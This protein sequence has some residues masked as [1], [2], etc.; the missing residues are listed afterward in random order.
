[1]SKQFKFEISGREISI[2]TGRLARLA[3][4]AVLIRMADT[5]VLATA[6]AG[7]KPREGV[8]FLPLV[9][10]Y[11]EKA[12]AAGKIPGGFFKREGRP[13]ER[14]I[15]SSRLIDRPLR[16]LFPDG[17]RHETQI[18][19]NVLSA[20]QENDPDILGIIGASCALHISQI[21]FNGPIGAVRVGRVDGRLIINPT[22]TQ[23]TEGDLNIVVVGTKDS[24][25]M[26]EAGAGIVG[27]EVI[28]SALKAAQEEIRKIVIIQEEM[29]E[30]IG[31]PKMDFIPDI[32]GEDLIDR[33]KSDFGPAIK[34]AIVVQG[35]EER[36]NALSKIEDKAVEK[37]AEDEELTA[38][39][40][41]IFS[42]LE[43]KYARK[44]ILEEN[45]RVDGRELKEI[46]P[47]TCE[48][49]SL[50]RTHGSAIFTRGETQALAITTLGT[51]DDE[52]MLDDLGT[53][54]SKSFMLH[55]NFPPFSVGEAGFLRGPGRR[56]IGHGALAER[57][58]RIS[59]PDKEQF[60]YT[61]R[62]VSEILESNGSSSMATICASSLSLMDAGVPIHNPIAGI[63]MGL[64]KEGDKVVILSD[65][66]GL[67]DHYGDMDFKVAGCRDGITALQMDIK[68]G[69]ITPVVMEE[70]L[71]QAREGRLFILDKML[72]T[73][74]APR[75]SISVYAPR[76]LTMKIK[77][78]KIREVIG[79][80]GKT[81][82]SIIE[83]TGVKIDVEDDGTVSIASADEEAALRAKTIIEEIIQ[84]AEVGRIYNGKVKKVVD[85]GA[86][87]EIFP[88][89]EGLVHISQLAD[90]RVAKV[91]DEINEG[92]EVLVKVI[93][94]DREGKIKLSRKEALRDRGKPITAQ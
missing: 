3:D 79:P 11:Q 34:E 43:K 10:N 47:I 9:V 71:M 70:A 81:I 28:I 30:A 7:K 40:S 61:V 31:R 41:E 59:I 22:N 94:I 4:G 75:E 90:Y 18:I 36:S 12:Y 52:Q 84:E 33:V 49:G 39:L 45:K 62:I 69:G 14:E 85:F 77:S 8:N 67:E 53:A 19:V 44:L 6:V 68:I 23:I 48:V 51:S 92:D 5:V 80:G 1:M 50:P 26:V 2:E 24:I 16:P 37:Y 15:L 65:I 38:R 76:I 66:L 60:P 46:R 86:F 73:L 55:Y 64:I 42:I 88:G 17:F 35:K 82:R 29:R 32:P 63:A 72:G 54:T 89:T 57:A 27:E 78:E 21:P 56:E 87:V 93:S 25:L 13:G 74:S 83:Q 91:Q 20:D 58:L